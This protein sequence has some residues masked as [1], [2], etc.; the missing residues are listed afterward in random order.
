MGF[1]NLHLD[2]TEALHLP[3][4]P[5]GPFRIPKLEAKMQDRETWEAFFGGPK[6]ERSQHTRNIHKVN[7]KAGTS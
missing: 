5:K 4:S 2:T 1:H 3:E 6:T 7:Y